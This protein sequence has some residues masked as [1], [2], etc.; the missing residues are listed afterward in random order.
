MSQA[1]TKYSGRAVTAMFPSR[2]NEEHQ[3]GSWMLFPRPSTSKSSSTDEW[4]DRRIQKQEVL[5]DKTVW[6]KNISKLL[7]LNASS[8]L[9]N[10][11][12]VDCGLRTT[13][14]FLSRNSGKWPRGY[15]SETACRHADNNKCLVFYTYTKI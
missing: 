12:R 5:A 1:W 9:S 3:M 8:R 4:V 14:S 15:F 6:T 7:R 2:Q 13:V 10:T 11:K